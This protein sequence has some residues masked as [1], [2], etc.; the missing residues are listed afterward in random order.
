MKAPE[1]DSNNMRDSYSVLNAT[2]IDIQERPSVLSHMIHK[3]AKEFQ[4]HLNA[5]VK[6][7]KKRIKCSNNANTDY[8]FVRKPEL[9]HQYGMLFNHHGQVISGLKNIDLFL[10][11]DLPKVEDIAHVP[12][13]FPDCDTWAAPHKSQK[14]S[15]AYY[16]VLG[17]GTDGHG[18]MA[19]FNNNTTHFLAEPLHIVVCNQYKLKYTNLLRRIETI[20]K[21]V[22]YKIEKVMP[23]LMPN[24]GA[25]TYSKETRIEYARY[26]RAIPLG[27]IF[28]GVSA[29]GGLIMK[30]I[31]HME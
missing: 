17:F 3:T 31:I 5:Y 18:P 10:S 22:T 6:T 1:Y 19:Q 26:K 16:S 20:K 21:N 4:K 9:R 23:K 7:I 29:I 25:F 12:P 28:T 8:G 30:G 11:V 24:E 15:T 2:T 27:L 13:E 14:H